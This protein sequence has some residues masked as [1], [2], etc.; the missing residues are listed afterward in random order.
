MVDQVNHRIEKFDPGGKYL[1]WFGGE[2]EDP[3]RLYYPMG[4]VI[5]C[6]DEIFVTDQ[7][8]HRV[9]IYDTEGNYFSSFGRRGSENGEFLFP[10]GISLDY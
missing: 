4:I 5:N 1:I 3:G 2:G 7:C 10:I 6:A 9:S 8:N